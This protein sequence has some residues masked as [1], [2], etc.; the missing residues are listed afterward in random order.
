M[1]LNAYDIDVA[2]G[3]FPDPIWPS[4]TFPELLKIAFKGRMIEDLDHPVLRRLRGE[5]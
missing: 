3:A 1:S 2:M 5:I 4:V